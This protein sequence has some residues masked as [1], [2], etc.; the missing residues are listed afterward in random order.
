MNV[1][2]SFADRAGAAA[3]AARGRLGRLR[4]RPAAGPD[5]GDA[6]PRD[7]VRVTYAAVLDAR[8]LCVATEDADVTVALRDQATGRIVSLDAETDPAAE[9]GTAVRIDLKGLSD[10]TD[11][12]PATFDV[13]AASPGVE[14]R[15]L[16]T[17]PLRHSLS[18]APAPGDGAR[19]DVG[20]GDDGRLELAVRA[21][22][23]TAELVGITPVPDGVELTLAGVRET[24][25]V[26]LR[27]AE[28]PVRARFPLAVS[29]G[30]GRATVTAAGLPAQGLPFAQVVVGT[31]RDSR[32][33]RR[34]DNGLRRANEA[35]MLPELYG[36]GPAPMARLRWADGGLLGIR[37]MHL[38]PATD[39]SDEDGAA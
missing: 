24:D 5:A 9:S 39:E 25:E 23:E 32:R 20:R 27:N 16:W 33:I 2:G 37:L 3:Q 4:Q 36:A 38:E 18:M 6:M 15:P 7:A 14:P 29:D 11:A 13:V 26:L 28:D 10:S 19:Y 1:G 34:R 21:Q 17:P 22:P 8:T 30:V 35:V 31:D 12:A